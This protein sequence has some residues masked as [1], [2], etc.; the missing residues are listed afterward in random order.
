[1]PLRHDLR[2][3][4]SD[5]GTNHTEHERMPC[6]CA[7]LPPIDVV[8]ESHEHEKG[9]SKF[10]KR[11]ALILVVHISQKSTAAE[12]GA[13]ECWSLSSATHKGLCCDY[14]RATFSLHHIDDVVA[15]AGA[16][17]CP[18]NLHG[19][20]RENYTLCSRLLP[21]VSRFV[22]SIVRAS[23]LTHFVFPVAKGPLS[24]HV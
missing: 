13:A 24:S 7:C 19:L 21:F 3:F 11:I 15:Y 20:S 9:L 23:K 10:R 17:K 5:I 22:G 16:P 6:F 4:L 2:L 18:Q 8:N 12:N 14:Q 1:M